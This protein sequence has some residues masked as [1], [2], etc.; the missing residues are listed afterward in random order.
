MEKQTLAKLIV[1]S[2]AGLSV[3]SG[4]RAFRTDT[5]S[6]KAMWDEYDL[7][8]VCNIQ[9][10]RG[11]FY[12]KTHTFYNK[13][14]EELGTVAPN[15]AHL[16][17]AEWFQRYPGKVKN[18]TT[19]V[20]D[21]LERAGIPEE[22]IVHVH[23]RLTHLRFIQREGDSEQCANI[24]YNQIDPDEY[25]W[26]KPDV[27]FFGEMAPKYQDM[28]NVFDDIMPDDVIVLVGCSN[29][30][31][32]FIWDLMPAV[33]RGTKLIVVNPQIDMSERYQM[34]ANNITYFRTTADDAFTN[35]EFLALVEGVLERG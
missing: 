23:G 30:V 16:R 34:E 24:G 19:N 31:I 28:Y 10:F 5:D 2:G 13:R 21:L 32:N 1:V 33:N 25:F 7:E 22:E 9:A 6:G 20:D 3:G 18:V 15:I 8:E 17:I 14:R 11:N 35:P 27:V 29:Q 4:I 12:H 26:C